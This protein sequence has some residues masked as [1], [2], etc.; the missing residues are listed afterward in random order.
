MLVLT[1]QIV[2]YTFPTIKENTNVGASDCDGIQ[3]TRHKIP[4]AILDTSAT[5]I[6]PYRSD[7]NLAPTRPVIVAKFIK[8][9]G[10]LASLGDRPKERVKFGSCN[11]ED[12]RRP[13]QGATKR[14]NGEKSEHQRDV[15][16]E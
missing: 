9:A 8:I 1:G 16:W 6:L 11:Q 5:V 13:R 7:T 14:P 10:R 2:L 15:V 12:T 3:N 4:L